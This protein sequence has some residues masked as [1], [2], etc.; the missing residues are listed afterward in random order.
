[1]GEPASVDCETDQMIGLVRQ[2]TGRV[3][4]DCKTDDCSCKSN[5]RTS[6]CRL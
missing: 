3:N 2:M 5:D 4:V 6:E 1:M